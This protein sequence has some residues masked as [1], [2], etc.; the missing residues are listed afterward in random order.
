MRC[1]QKNKL[2]YLQFTPSKD[3]WRQSK[4]YQENNIIAHYQMT[5]F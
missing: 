4:E 5:K 1:K 2:Q 3:K